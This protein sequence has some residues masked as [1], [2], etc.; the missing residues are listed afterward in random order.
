MKMNA[1]VKLI[2]I[3]KVTASFG[4]MA[5]PKA[6]AKK[7]SNGTPIMEDNC[8]AIYMINMIQYSFFKIK[9]LLLQP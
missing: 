8:I 9:V 2:N 7:M 3:H 1:T 5:H 6:L 4:E